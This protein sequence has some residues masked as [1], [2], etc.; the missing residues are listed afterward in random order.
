MSYSGWVNYETWNVALWLDNDE[1]SYWQAREMVR[2]L[3]EKDNPH[4]FADA[5]KD[6]VADS[7]P[8]LGASCYSDLLTAALGKVSWVEIA[9][10]YIADMDEVEDAGVS[11]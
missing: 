8:E 6:W 7:A 10:H 5:L 4:P 3:G 9:E 2:D 11:S 1:G